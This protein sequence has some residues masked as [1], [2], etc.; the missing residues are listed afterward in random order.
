M[1]LQTS[2]HP[3]ERCRRSRERVSKDALSFMRPSFPATDGLLQKVPASCR[4]AG[5]KPAI[6][7]LNLAAAPDCRLAVPVAD[8]VDGCLEALGPAVFGVEQGRQIGGR[9][10]SQA[11]GA[12]ADQPEPGRA[13]GL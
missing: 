13:V 3:E 11:V 7:I 12:D 8:G 4:H 1:P 2:P 5:L 9:A 10:I 6:P